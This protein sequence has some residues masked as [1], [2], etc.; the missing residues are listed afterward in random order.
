[1]K[2]TKI[3][4]WLA[5][6]LAVAACSSS[7]DPTPSTSDAGADATT[8][9]S[10]PGD[11]ARDAPVDATPDA[12]VDA[13][14][15]AAPDGGA[16]LTGGA[17]VTPT[18][19][20]S[21]ADPYVVD[22]SAMALGTVVR[23]DLANAGFEP[24]FGGPCRTTFAGTMRDLVVHVKMP[25]AVASLAVGAEGPGPTDTVI[26]VFEDPSCG[27]P[28]NACASAT[29]AGA[30]EHL[31]APRSGAGFFGTSTY[32]IVSEPVNHGFALTVRLRA[33]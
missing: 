6:T 21:C 14:T 28:I 18:G 17:V 32:V 11:A 3:V 15:D 9:D 1:M 22:I 16:C 23:V 5:A 7:A 19:S 12:A 2:K 26:G 31:V 13:A 25:T 10:G 24:D 29:G 30:C 33:D 27:Q 8:S 20:G 4:A